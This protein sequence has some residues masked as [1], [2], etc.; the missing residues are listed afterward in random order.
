MGKG[1]EAN[2]LL[3]GG[4]FRSAMIRIL[5]HLGCRVLVEARGFTEVPVY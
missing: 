3:D 5:E 1:C 2:K 4:R